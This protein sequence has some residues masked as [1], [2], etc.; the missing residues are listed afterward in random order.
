[1]IMRKFILLVLL[2]L[3]SSVSLMAQNPNDKPAW[4]VTL[5]ANKTAGSNLTVQNR[6]K[7]KHDFDIKKQNLSY[8]EI[9]QTQVS[10]G[11]GGNVNVPVRF[12][13]T[14][15]LPNTYQGQVIVICKTCSKEPTCTQD[16]EVLPVILNVTDIRAVSDPSN[17]SNGN[18]ADNAKASTK[19]KDPCKEEC[20]DLLK[21]ANDK[22][23]AAKNAQDAADTAKANADKEADAA[24]S[25]DDAAKKAEEMAKDIPRNDHAII[26]GDKFTTADTEYRIQLQADINAAHKAGQISDKEH[27]RQTK[28]NTTKKARDERLKNLARLKKEAEK[29]RAAADAAKRK[30]AKAKADADAAQK[31]ADDAKKEADDARNA[32]NDCVKKAEEECNKIKAAEAKRIADEKAAE[33]K[34]LADIKAAE[35]ARIAEEKR[36]ADAEKKRQEDIA[37]RKRLLELIKKLGLIDKKLS[38]VPSIWGWLPEA[39]QVPVSMFL[40][41]LAAVPIP[42]DTLTALGGLYGLIEVC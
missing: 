42:T 27:E 33:A 9:S 1:M 12:N 40:E 2:V 26:N 28:A 10:V 19:K 15:L 18:D 36:K 22:N 8:L 25:A 16:R 38:D 14:N 34:R 21:T 35:D 39:D 7:K 3:V 29:A 20:L 32:Y 31:A 24:K 41:N 17:D 30:A 5:A 23:S 4:N 11:G 37:E 6:C 13:T